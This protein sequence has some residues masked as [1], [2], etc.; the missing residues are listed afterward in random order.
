M[1]VS[2][3]APLS[4]FDTVSFLG[5]KERVPRTILAG[6]MCWSLIFSEAVRVGSSGV[7]IP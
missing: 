6:Y 4:P 5:C 1:L 3:Q 2:V 7:C